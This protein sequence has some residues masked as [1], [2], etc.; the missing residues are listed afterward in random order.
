[1]TD[2]VEKNLPLPNL[3]LLVHRIPYPPNK[4]DKIRSYHLLQHLTKH[5]RVYMGCFVD[6]Q[7]DLQYV[8]KVESLVCGSYFAPLDPLDARLHSLPALLHGRAMSLDYYASDKMRNWVNATLDVY[9]IER[10]VVFSSVM[11][12]YIEHA[13][14]ARR[15]IDFVD[16]DSDKWL[17]YAQKKWWPLSWLYRR[18][19]NRLL[20]YERKLTEMCDLALFVSENESELFKR[21]APESCEKISYYNNGVDSDYF[22][23]H[24]PDAPD[25]SHPNPYPQQG[26]FIVFTGAMD[27]WPNC[28]AVQWFVDAILPGIQKRCPGTLFYIVGARPTKSVLALTERA[29]VKVTGSVPDVR[30]FLAHAHVAVAPLRIARGIQ[31]KVLEAMAMAKT[32][33][34]SPEAL[35]GIEAQPDGEVLLADDASQYIDH[36]SRLLSGLQRDLG[37]AARQKVLS[38]YSW[39]HNLA[40]IN[41]MLEGTADAAH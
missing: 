25:L 26:Q 8:S 32:V 11:G 36:V 5:Y 14:S 38:R 18:E 37:K 12:Q 28:D 4:G 6:D 39:E 16:I 9:P 27:Y 13:D 33:V 15:V 34:V 21:L 23:P 17:Q 2:D 22:C 41:R 30:P 29:G 7:D 3:L 19:G 24:P 10:I 31:N 40:G 35:S 20:D 1:M